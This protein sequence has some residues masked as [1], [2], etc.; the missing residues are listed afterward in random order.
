[1]REAILLQALCSPALTVWGP[2]GYKSGPLA[3]EA[4]GAA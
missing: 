4:V 2:M 3:S 1:M